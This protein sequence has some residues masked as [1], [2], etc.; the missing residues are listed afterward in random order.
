MSKL[1]LL[2]LFSLSAFAGNTMMEKVRE[3]AQKAD[4]KTS[5][6]S[7]WCFETEA[8]NDE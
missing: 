8:A 3:S 2:G 7:C 6:C 4:E 1:L 5:Q